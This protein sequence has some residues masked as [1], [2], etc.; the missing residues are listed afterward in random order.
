M[1]YSQE[2]RELPKKIME[3]TGLEE[4][5]KEVRASTQAAAADINT[6]VN[7]SMQDIRKTTQ[8]AAAEMNQ[9][10]KDSVEA[11]RVPE[12]E[13][14]RLDTGT[15]QTIAPPALTADTTSAPA[16]QEAAPAV[17]E[18]TSVEVVP[19]LPAETAGAAAPAVVEVVA[20]TPAAETP[21]KPRRK[22]AEAA[23]AEAAPELAAPEQSTSVEPANESPVVE[24]PQPARRTRA[25]KAAPEVQDD[26]A[27]QTPIEVQSSDLAIQLPPDNGQETAA[28]KKRR[29]KRAAQVPE[30]QQNPE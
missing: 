9:A 27:V 3:D 17:I 30:D 8:E 4:T 16:A 6:A 19:E 11:A 28:P 12:A 10:V 15:N 21:K 29:A 5:L 25:R 1:G 26:L 23:P 13:H 14:L 24:P 7:E 2:I 20:G 18:T 22:R